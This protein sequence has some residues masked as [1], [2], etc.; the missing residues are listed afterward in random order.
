MDWRR[1][2]SNWRDYTTYDVEMLI[3]ENLPPK[4][5]WPDR[6]LRAEKRVHRL[7]M[8]IAQLRAKNRNDPRIT[9]LRAELKRITSIWPRRK[10][11]A[12]IMV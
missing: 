12:N 5:S 1:F 3:E 8:R 7:T 10:V 6:S 9:P 11:G 4:K 2:F